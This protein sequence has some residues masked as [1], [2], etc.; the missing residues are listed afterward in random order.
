M[1]N[2]AIMSITYDIHALHTSQNLPSSAAS[3]LKNAFKGVFQ[4]VLEVGAVSITRNRKREAILLSAEL[5]DQII[6]ELAARDPLETL[7]KDYDERFVAMQ[8]DKAQAGYEDAF[9]ASPGEL[10]KAAVSSAAVSSTSGQ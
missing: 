4:Q 5:Y 3:E 2:I 7:R 10:G 6:A 8:T 1:A 9:D